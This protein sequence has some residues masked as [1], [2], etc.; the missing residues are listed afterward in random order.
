M[1]R[2][3]TNIVRILA[4]IIAVYGVLFGPVWLPIIVIV[5]LSVRFRAWEALL[6]GMSMD[7]IWMP[8]A[9]LLPLMPFFTIVALVIV[10]G[11]EPL[12]RELMLS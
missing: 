12:R 4:V 8:S 1:L 5:L 2:L 6:V 11:F 7:L 10:W 9:S 3:P